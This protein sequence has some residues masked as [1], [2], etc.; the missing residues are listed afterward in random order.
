MGLELQYK[1]DSANLS[2]TWSYTPASGVN[3]EEKSTIGVP[4]DTYRVGFTFYF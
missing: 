1:K 3:I 4:S 2:R